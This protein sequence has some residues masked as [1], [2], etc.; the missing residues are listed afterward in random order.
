MSHVT[1]LKPSPE[2]ELKL[3]PP[4][5]KMQQPTNSFIARPFVTSERKLEESNKIFPSGNASV[6]ITHSTE[7]KR[8][9]VKSS[10]F[11]TAKEQL[12]RK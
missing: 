12:V 11:C 4:V 10:A 8:E 6:K 3:K 5:V 1:K 7:K 2:N 9:E